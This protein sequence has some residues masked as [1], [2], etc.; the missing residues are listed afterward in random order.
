MGLELPAELDSYGC[1]I[2]RNRIDAYNAIKKADY[3]LGYIQADAI[4]VMLLNIGA[5]V[6]G[7]KYFTY[8]F[9]HNPDTL[10]G[11]GHRDLFFIGIQFAFN[12]LVTRKLK[13]IAY[14][15]IKSDG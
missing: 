14:D 10:V 15:I 5:T 6:K 9:A 13:G 7:L 12:G 4:A 1:I 8:F 11:N 2:T 3:F